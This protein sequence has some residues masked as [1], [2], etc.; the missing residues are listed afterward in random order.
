M[1]S[2]Y[3]I[4]TPALSSKSPAYTIPYTTALVKLPAVLITL[5]FDV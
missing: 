1:Y 5:E 3:T 4:A 2:E